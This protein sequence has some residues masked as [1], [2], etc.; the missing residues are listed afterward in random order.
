HAANPK[1][2]QHLHDAG[3]LVNAPGET[4]RH[5]YPHCWRCKNPVLFRATPQWFASLEKNDL[6]KRALD[7]IDA[8]Q[9]VPPWGRNRIFGMIEPRPDWCLSRQRVW[10]TPLPVF[11]CVPCDEPLVDAGVMRFVA[12]QFAKEGAD[13]WWE[14]DAGALV[15]PGT[16]CKKC[17]G[18]KFRKDN[19]I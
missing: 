2:V 16:T 14:R 11:F 7:A 18:K 13:V 15:P 12:D 4:L 10:G 19:A 5:S 1:I 6:R 3:A 9:W 8:T 17:G